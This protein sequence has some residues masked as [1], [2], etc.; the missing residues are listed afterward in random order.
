[1]GRQRCPHK[2]GAKRS[3]H[4]YATDFCVKHVLP[5]R[6]K[7]GQQFLVLSSDELKE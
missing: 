4:H 3:T 5:P 1:M 2:G 6:E 7:R